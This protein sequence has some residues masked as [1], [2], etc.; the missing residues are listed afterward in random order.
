MRQKIGRQP[1][2]GNGKFGTK[3]AMGA[4]SVPFLPWLSAAVLHCKLSWRGP[5]Y[6]VRQAL[7][8]TEGERHDRCQTGRGARRPLLKLAL[9][10]LALL[11]MLACGNSAEE[12]AASPT[13]TP[14]TGPITRNIAERP[15]AATP[16]T[17]T[18]VQVTIPEKAELKHPKVVGSMLDDLIARVEAGE[19]SAEDAAREAPVQDGDS[20]AVTIYLSGNVDEV[21][22]FLE[23]NSGS[24]PQRRRGL[25]RSLRAG[26]A[27]G[28]D[29]GATRR[30][31]GAGNHPA[32]AGRGKGPVDR[33]HRSCGGFWRR[34]TMGTPARPSNGILQHRQTGRKDARQQGGG[35]DYRRS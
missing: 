1:V 17:G 14:A 22:R 9:G 19:I 13:A 24:P 2:V 6:P 5:V 7:A 10:A 12:P 11:A 33:E 31:P 26:D 27:A 35:S 4:A 23:D 3:A 8:A 16:A 30:H 28:A 15:G 18:A 20:V 34:G 21:V 25:H 32:A 29:L